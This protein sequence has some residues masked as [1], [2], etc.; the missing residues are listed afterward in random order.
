MTGPM[1]P[2]DRTSPMARAALDQRAAMLSPA[3]AAQRQ[4]Q[5]PGA[6]PF[7]GP[8]QAG[9]M[10][11][12][13]GREGIRDQLKRQL[14]QAMAAKN[15][16]SAA[17]LIDLLQAEREFQDE[18][19]RFGEAKQYHA[20][21]RPNPGIDAF[22]NAASPISGAWIAEQAGGTG[23]RKRFEASMR[24]YAVEHPGKNLA[25]NLAGGVALGAATGGPA[26]AL[27]G[28]MG[29]GRG[30]QMAIAGAVPGAIQGFNQA[31]EGE[32]LR[33]AVAGGVVGAVLGRAMPAVGQ[34]LARRLAPSVHRIAGTVD[35]AAVA[36]RQMQGIEDEGRQVLRA[37]TVDDKVSPELAPR[38]MRQGA[39][40]RGGWKE[41]FEGSEARKAFQR[42]VVAAIEEGIEDGTIN[43][44]DGS[45]KRAQN[46]ARL[47]L[48]HSTVTG[49]PGNVEAE[50][51]I[52]AI[53]RAAK[54]HMST[55]VPDIDP[56]AGRWM[57]AV[58]GAGRGY[59]G[60]A[61]GMLQS[62]VRG[63][64]GALQQLATPTAAQAPLVPAWLAASAAPMATAVRSSGATTGLTGA[65]W[66]DW[67]QEQARLA[68]EEA[69]RNAM[70]EQEVRDPR[71]AVS[72]KR[73]RMAR[74]ALQK[75]R[76]GE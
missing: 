64:A 69:A 68:E 46:A 5:P 10:Q 45:L 37:F 13:A 27:A 72:R 58:G 47:V 30:A 40:A 51:V 26:G 29:A 34:R 36:S 75:K 44:A 73:A 6:P 21:H 7:V 42:G 60:G 33:G 19:G 52:R 54:S 49:K 31:E 62:M 24:N 16:K 15:E 71:S 55:T 25:A 61:G 66:H 65:M 11:P 63:G 18:G 20:T 12:A 56:N 59:S 70:R 28:R 3:A 50:E 76:R 74:E 4:G 67:R 14:A 1:F 43:A 35:E 9:P 39:P 38:L 2:D 53:D 22:A 17:I 57:R 41:T 32:G 48:G 8:P 23:A